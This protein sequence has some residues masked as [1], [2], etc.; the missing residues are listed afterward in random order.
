MSTLDNILKE[1]YLNINSEIEEVNSLV[2]ELD[3]ALELTK[4]QNQKSIISKS[5][6][7]NIIKANCATIKQLQD[8][9]KLLLYYKVIT[10]NDY[11]IKSIKNGRQ[12]SGHFDLIH[13]FK[14]SANLITKV[15]SFLKAHVLD[16]SSLYTKKSIT[17]SISLEDFNSMVFDFN[18]IYGQIH[19]E[20]E[21]ISEDVIGQV[22]DKKYKV[23]Y[24]NLSELIAK[25][26]VELSKDGSLYVVDEQENKVHYMSLYKRLCSA[27]DLL[28]IKENQG[29]LKALK[30]ENIDSL[31]SC[32]IESKLPKVPDLLFGKDD[33]QKVLSSSIGV[34]YDQTIEILPGVSAKFYNAAHLPWSTQVLITF[35]KERDLSIPYENKLNKSLKLLFTGD[36]GK[37]VQNGSENELGPIDIPDENIDFVLQET[38]YGDREHK[39]TVKED[40]EKLL[41]FVKSTSGTILAAVFAN[42][43]PQRFMFR[44][45]E[46]IQQGFLPK[47]YKIYFDS[48]LAYKLHLNRLKVNPYISSEFLKHPSFEFI[49]DK[50]FSLE[51]IEKQ[52]GYAPFVGSSSG[53]MVG[54]TIEK[55]LIEFLPKENNL[56]LAAGYMSEGTRGRQIFDGEDSSVRCKIDSLGSF[57]GH[58]DRRDLAWY[59]SQLKLN[60]G[61]QVVNNHGDDESINSFI[62]YVKEKKILADFVSHVEAKLDKEIFIYKRKEVA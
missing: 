62:N 21:N 51:K 23:I 15:V 36:L 44:F 37:I 61:A 56:L 31:D 39:S 11:K 27:Y 47:D 5:D 60:D 57:S 53:M 49:T 43:R 6:S 54:G 42:D 9:K 41:N 19:S 34:D 13:T 2:S 55:H 3:S 12:D 24:D 20:L 33:I 16:F 8:A 50:T 17:K 22:I 59:L 7:E 35:N 38:T 4:N 10:E 29:I 46:L 14:E 48:P 30:D 40:N 58:A 45:Y 1:A 26:D 25:S 18:N 28:S 32:D 52:K